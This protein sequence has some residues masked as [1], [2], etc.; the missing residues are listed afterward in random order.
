M[1]SNLQWYFQQTEKIFSVD[2]WHCLLKMTLFERALRLSW[3]VTSVKLNN[4]Q[5]IVTTLSTKNKGRGRQMALLS[6]IARTNKTAQPSPSM[7]SCLEGNPLCL[8]KK[9]RVAEQVLRKT[10]QCFVILAFVWVSVCA[11]CVALQAKCIM[12]GHTTWH[13][14][15]TSSLS[16]Y[17]RFSLFLFL[18]GSCSEED[19]AFFKL[20][21]ISLCPCEFM[22]TAK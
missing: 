9:N 13:C 5:C 2:F 16:L 7:K 19:N 8:K 12:S 11:E 4:L 1:F 6:L 20:T 17:Y 10:Q 14:Y 18:A 3:Q 22:C 15:I 21:L